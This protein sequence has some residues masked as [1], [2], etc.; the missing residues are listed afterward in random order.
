MDVLKQERLWRRAVF[1]RAVALAYAPADKAVA[2]LESFHNISALIPFK[3]G[4]PAHSDPGLAKEAAKVQPDL[5]AL[6]R[7][8][9]GTTV[10]RE[11]KRAQ[12][13]LAEHRDHI[14]VDAY[15]IKPATESGARDPLA[16][17]LRR[18]LR[19]WEKAVSIL[20]NALEPATWMDFSRRTC[21]DSLDLFCALVKKTVA[22]KHL[23]PP[24]R[25]CKFPSCNRL[26]FRGRRRGKFCSQK[27][28]SKFHSKT[29]QM[30]RTERRQYQYR[31]LAK[32]LPVA[33]L[34]ARIAQVQRRKIRPEKKRRLFRILHSVL[35]QGSSKKSSN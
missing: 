25:I 29:Y 22:E 24:V 10:K 3:G 20:T 18:H 31:Y 34:R 4:A 7:L 15:E 11:I 27:C 23:E 9:A 32:Q 28:K 5:Q 19:L 33:A 35:R 6:L 17:K 16:E 13:I 12:E 30:S 14:V 2:A 8:V 1:A 21:R 26:F